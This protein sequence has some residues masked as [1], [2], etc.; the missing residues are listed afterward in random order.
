MVSANF[1][2]IN[3]SQ[4]HKLLQNQQNSK[5]ISTEIGSQLDNLKDHPGHKNYIFL[6]LLLR[7][8][9]MFDGDPESCNYYLDY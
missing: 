6:V 3:Q 8:E 4:I 1:E 7:R 5:V 9:T 2:L